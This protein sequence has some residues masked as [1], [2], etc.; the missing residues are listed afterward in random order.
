MQEWKEGW[1]VTKEE[2]LA[3]RRG[4]PYDAMGDFSVFFEKD[5]KNGE[6]G[7]SGGSLPENPVKQ[8]R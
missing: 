2:N 4:C 3:Y 8:V 7:K 5:K 1:N 6:T